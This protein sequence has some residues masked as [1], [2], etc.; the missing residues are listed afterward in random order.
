M[1]V[2][3]SRGRKPVA[4]AAVLTALALT[5]ALAV[6][7]ATASEGEGQVK[8]TGTVAD[9]RESDGS[10]AGLEHMRRQ[11]PLVEAAKAI[12]I[13]VE[14]RGYASQYA[15][16]VLRDTDHVDLYWKGAV[17]AAVRRVV[18]KASE[19][20]PVQVHSAAYSIAELRN[21]SRQIEANWRGEPE[22]L[23]A[24]KAQPDGS[25]LIVSA[26]ASATADRAASL[27]DVGV[28]LTI[29][30]E[31]PIKQTIDRGT[32]IPPWA[33][34]ARIV[35]AYRGNGSCTSGFG[36]R[37]S[38][39][40]QYILTAA[41]CGIPGD[42]FQSGTGALIGYM[43]PWQHVHDVALV[44]TSRADAYIYSGCYNCG[45]SRPVG[46]WEHTFV[47]EYLCQSGQATARDT[48]DELCDL[49]VRGFHTDGRGAVE[50]QQRSGLQ[51][52][53]PGDSG[54]PVYSI[55]ENQA[56]AKGTTIGV[57]VNRPSLMIF[58]D[59]ATAFE[60]FGGIVPVTF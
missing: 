21:A 38:A 53:R 10:T 52:S 47:G 9:S 33:G 19:T 43:G 7:P 54:G 46:R 22:D 32:D 59:F 1:T 34:G 36:V 4:I 39:G 13:E 30:D 16:I 31:G 26:A 3:L 11:H 24:I 60:D 23:Y 28:S 48:G 14:R 45:D 29:V 58:Q 12:R 25:G 20:A 40:A 49:I 37:N 57:G 44:P 55:H 15:S 17:P 56:I 2:T 6:L 51:G 18:N 5:T 50:A 41:H 8:G 42:R 35:N 27:P